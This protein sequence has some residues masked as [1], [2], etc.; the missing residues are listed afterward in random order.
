MAALSEHFEV[1]VL[2]GDRD[3]GDTEPFPGVPLN[4]WLVHETGAKVLYAAEGGL[5]RIIFKALLVQIRPQVVYLNS[6]FSLFFSIRPL[7]WLKKDFPEIKVVLAPRGMLKDSALAFKR[8]KKQSFLLIARLLGWYRKVHFQATDAEEVK[9]IR[10]FFGPKVVLTQLSNLPA[11]VAAYQT[12]PEGIPHFIFVGRIHPIK[13]LAL[14]IQAFQSIVHPAVLTIVGNVED[15]G[16]FQYCQTLAEQ[17][18][19]HLQLHWRGGL[20]HAEIQKLLHR[21]HFFILPT[22]GE[23]FGHAIFEAF[24]TGTPVL[25]SD[26]TPWQDLEPQKIGWDLPLSQP[27]R[28]VATIQQAM[29]MDQEEYT[30]WSRAAH[31]FAERYFA[32]QDLVGRYVDLFST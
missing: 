15:Q 20:P 9:A 7:F 3:L 1:W 29:A 30:T 28:W 4:R 31:A 25:I 13:G 8:S 23:N 2:T 14:A 17:V 12:K 27:Q 32:E 21:H 24:A 6:M 26:Q 18:P 22:H 5:Q 10:R 16:Y 11:P 19:D